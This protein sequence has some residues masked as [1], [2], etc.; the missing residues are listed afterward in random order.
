[1]IVSGSVLAVFF[2]GICPF[3]GRM[4]QA[5][6]IMCSGEKDFVMVHNAAT[7]MVEAAPSFPS[8]PN[9]ATNSELAVLQLA[10]P[11]IEPGNGFNPPQFLVQVARSGN[12]SAMLDMSVSD[13]QR[14]LQG[15]ELNSVGKAG[16]HT[17]IRRLELRDLTPSLG[18]MLKLQ[19]IESAQIDDL[20]DELACAD[21]GVSLNEQATLALRRAANREKQHGHREYQ[22]CAEVVWMCGWRNRSQLRVICPV[23]C[24]CGKLVDSP[25]N[26]FA[27]SQFGC[28]RACESEFKKELLGG[29]AAR[30]EDVAPVRFNE[31]HALRSYFNQAFDFWL[32][33]P[34]MMTASHTA[35]TL[36][37][38]EL[39]I[40][41][42]Q[43][44][45]AFTS[46]LNG[47]FLESNLAGR[48]EFP[49]G[50]RHPRGLT[51]CQ[52]WASWEV[53]LM[54]GLDFCS[55]GSFRSLRPYCPVSCGC[56]QAGGRQCPTACSG[57]PAPGSQ[58]LEGQPAWPRWPKS[59]H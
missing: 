6:N 18:V 56:L 20:V 1:M 21:M 5:Y 30:C 34:E 50:H 44:G 8:A 51:G 16:E 57:D 41:R 17:A 27:S 3:Y 55:S 22:K 36:K 14:V 37:A 13:L 53:T 39:D 19:K 23:T 25:A 43:S 33:R 49:H 10:R 40:P 24:G 4:N 11:E 35:V 26:F 54:L 29:R 31:D 58:P 46:L 28:P 7:G 59:P 45:H 15:L 2:Y 38:E 32:S 42:N 9:N 52:F 12:R 47:S 48:W